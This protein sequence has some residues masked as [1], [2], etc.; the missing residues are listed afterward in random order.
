MTSLF[1]SLQGSDHV[2]DYAISF[3]YMSVDKMYAMEYFVY[4]LR[5]FGILSGDQK[6]NLKRSEQLLEHKTQNKTTTRWP[7]ITWVKIQ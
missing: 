7:V 1:F 5:P 2:S 4:H 3:H 6:L